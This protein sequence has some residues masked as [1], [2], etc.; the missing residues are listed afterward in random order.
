MHPASRCVLLAV[1]LAVAPSNASAQAEPRLAVA[2]SGAPAQAGPRLALL[3]VV[4]QLI[5]ERLDPQLPGGIGRLAREGRVYA[6]A[7]HDHA[8]TETCPGHAAI[9]TG[10]HPAAAGISGNEFFDPATGRKLYCVADPSPETAV[11]GADPKTPGGRSPHHLRV[12]ALGDWLKASHPKSRVFAVSGKDRAA[13]LLGGRRPDGAWW[14]QAG[15]RPGLHHESL[16]SRR[17]SR[18]G[19]AVQRPGSPPRRLLAQDSP[20]LGARRDRGR[21]PRSSGRLPG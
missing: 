16:L 17:D 15:P 12:S 13:I 18:V 19:E 5:P 3:I 4:D 2:P 20:A 1:L 8:I 11:F 7:F 6:E 14:Y 21:G 9:A 10:R